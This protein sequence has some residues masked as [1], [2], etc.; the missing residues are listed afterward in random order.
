LQPHRIKIGA[1]VIL[2]SL[3]GLAVDWGISMA[4]VETLLNLLEIPRIKMP[5]GDKRYV[6]LYPLETA[7]FELGLPEAFKKD[8]SF[9][10][11]QQELCGVLYGTLSR[12]VIRERCKTLTA[13]LRAYSPKKR[14]GKR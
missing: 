13:A 5:E 9:V 12:E 1:S 10:L 11:A 7:L 14:K 6:S 8:P 2:V 3:D 4:G